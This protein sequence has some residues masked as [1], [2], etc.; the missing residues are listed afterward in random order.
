MSGATDVVIEIIANAFVELASRMCECEKLKE[1]HLKDLELAKAADEIAK[2][3]SDGRE[4][5][6]GPVVIKIERKLLGRRMRVWLYGNE[7]SA[8]LLLSE[9]SKAK[10]RAA[11]IHSDCSENALLELL[12]KY[13]DRY[14]IEVIQRNFDKIKAVCRGE[15][16]ALD[17]GE[18]PA[19]VINGVMEGLKLFLSRDSN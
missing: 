18:A 1:I 4:G 2:A 7:T 19:Y 12:Y 15:A 9:L 17:F 16:P 8:D 5:E 13:E 14:L 6:F 10:S 11:W 3:V